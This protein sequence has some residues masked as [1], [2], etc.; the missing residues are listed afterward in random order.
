MKATSS[1]DDRDDNSPVEK[2]GPVHDFALKPTLL[3]QE[4]V[5]QIRAHM[6]RWRQLLLAELDLLESESKDTQE[7]NCR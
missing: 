3:G 5:D 6:P 4:T 7:V 2:V 1:S